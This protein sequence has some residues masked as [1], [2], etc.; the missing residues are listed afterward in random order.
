MSEVVAGPTVRSNSSVVTSVSPVDVNVMVQPEETV[1]A[2]MR[3]SN[4]P[5]PASALSVVVDAPSKLP[6]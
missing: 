4:V 3:S 5:T 2:G 6:V 1:P